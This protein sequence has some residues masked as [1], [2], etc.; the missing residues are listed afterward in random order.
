MLF[1]DSS[2]R[3]ECIGNFFH[4]II[5]FRQSKPEGSLSNTSECYIKQ[6]SHKLMAQLLSF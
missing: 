3:F 1:L 2:S 6:V 5:V 4:G